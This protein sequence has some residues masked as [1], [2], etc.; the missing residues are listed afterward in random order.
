M[1]IPIALIIAAVLLFLLI[2]PVSF[3]DDFARILGLTASQMVEATAW[4]SAVLGIIINAGIAQAVV[5]SLAKWRSRPRISAAPGYRALRMLEWV[6]TPKTVNRVFR[7]T[8]ADMQHEHREALASG[9]VWKARWVLLRGRWSLVSAA[10][11][12]APFSVLKRLYEIWKAV[13]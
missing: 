3:V 12:Q 9:R 8:V 6:F 4:L 11:A 13:G 7:P 1:S 5:R 2:G 10:L